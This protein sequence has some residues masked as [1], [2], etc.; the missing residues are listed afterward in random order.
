MYYQGDGPF[1]RTSRVSVYRS[2]TVTTS[3]LIST[4]TVF[5][6]PELTDDRGET[7]NDNGHFRVGISDPVWNECTIQEGKRHKQEVAA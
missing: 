5:W 4:G 3:T 7:R 1:C 6:L 2:V